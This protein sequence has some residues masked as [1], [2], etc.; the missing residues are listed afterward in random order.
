MQN[1]TQS[2]DLTFVATCLLANKSIQ[3]ISV[4][5]DF[6]GLKI[7]H[8]SPSKEIDQLRSQYIRGEILLSPLALANQIRQ[9]KTWPIT[10]YDN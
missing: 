4:T 9:L 5:Q 3:V 1:T 2:N 6:K 7:F 8:L 10:N